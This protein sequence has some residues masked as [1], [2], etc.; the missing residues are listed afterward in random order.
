VNDYGKEADW[1]CWPGRAGDACHADLTT[2]II[3]ADGSVS[4]EPFKANSTAPIDCFYVYPT[5]SPDPGVLSTIAVRPAERDAAIQQFARFA[6][7]CRTFAPL[8]RQFTVAAMMARMRGQPLSM[9]GI[10]PDI[11]F[12]DVR[13]AW[14]YYLVRQNHGRGVVLIG[15]SQGSAMLTRLI[16]EEIDGKPAQRLL[17]S[18]ILLGTNLAVRSDGLGD[19]KHIPLCRSE[20]Q[21]GCAIVYD[22]F[23]DDSPPPPNSPLG[24]LETPRPGMEAACVNPAT[25]ASGTEELH[26]YLDSG[27]RSDSMTSVKSPQTPWVAGRPPTTPFVSVPGLLS[28][29]CVYSPPFT[30]LAIQIHGD[31][32]GARTSQIAG[33]VIMDGVV[34]KSFGLHPIDANLAMGDL[35]HIVRRQTAAWAANPP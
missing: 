32:A 19:F 10:S 22:S 23:R 2:T 11:P 6:S 26:S 20:N 17:V 33:D 31:P 34:Q 13:D 12:N 1:L 7:V 30:Y 27:V 15:H 3:R 28:A 8:Y 21:Y 4:V 18:A 35:I 25:L 29:H 16:Q 5:V 14:H 9:S 24:R